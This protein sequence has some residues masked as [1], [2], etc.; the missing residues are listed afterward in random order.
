MKHLFAI[1]LF[2]VIALPFLYA[3]NAVLNLWSGKLYDFPGD[4]KWQLV[5]AHGR[6]L[7]EGN[8]CIRFQLPALPAG[9]SLD[10]YLEN[11]GKKQK[12]CFYSPRLFT[13]IQATAF[14]L[15]IKHEKILQN[16]GVLL[17]S[18]K[19]KSI[20]FASHIV[21]NFPGKIL[22]V[23]LR[24]KD[25]PLKL[26][27]KWTTISLHHTKNS[28]HLS[29]LYNEKEKLLDNNGNCTYVKLKKRER[30]VIMFSPDFDLENI[31]NALLIKNIAENNIHNEGVGE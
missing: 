11:G 24:K 28:G 19:G 26:D 22:F 14:D 27:D 3:D 15:N 31:E 30:Y 8:G 17:V 6:V 4:G 9:S 13:G 20:G 18:L 21:E 2:L 29:V 5:A 10:A 25:F 12:L 23:F 1:L 16:S 7:A